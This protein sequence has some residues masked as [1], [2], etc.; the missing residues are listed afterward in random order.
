MTT[1]TIE[2]YEERWGELEEAFHA[3][4][5]TYSEDDVT[6]ALDN[7]LNSLEIEVEPRVTQG[8]WTY[9]QECDIGNAPHQNIWADCV[10]IAQCV[11]NKADAKYMSGSKRL[12]KLL[13][14]WMQLPP[15]SVYEG[16]DIEMQG[17][18]NQLDKMGVD[19]SEFKQGVT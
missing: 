4:S 13:L 1:I 19:V 16:N 8:D 15:V 18:I 3:V 2:D 17:L 6:D 12:V 7:I 14:A 9:S 5:A 11:R 10:C